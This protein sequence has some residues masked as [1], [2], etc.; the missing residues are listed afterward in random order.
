MGTGGWRAGTG[1]CWVGHTSVEGERLGH[2]GWVAHKHIKYIH[3]C[4]HTK[5][6]TYNV[7]KGILL[8]IGHK[9]HVQVPSTSK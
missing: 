5:P 6:A 4:M 1:L 3:M 8:Q 9:V 2:L 7:S